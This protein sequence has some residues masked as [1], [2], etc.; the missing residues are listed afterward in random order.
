MTLQGPVVTLGSL[1]FYSINYLSVGLKSLCKIDETLLHSPGPALLT[2]GTMC[3]SLPPS[4]SP[5]R[6]LPNTPHYAP[7]DS[8]LKEKTRLEARKILYNVL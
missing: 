8:L 1:L 4:P 6:S 7:L 2:S 5:S 3:G